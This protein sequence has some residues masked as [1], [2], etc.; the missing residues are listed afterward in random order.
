MTG[1]HRPLMEGDDDDEAQRVDRQTQGKATMTSSIANLCNTIIGTGMLA[2][3]G[4]FR[5]TGL[6][7]GIFLILLCGFTALAG[8]LLLT[9]CADTLGGRKNSFFS[10]A[11]HTLPRGARVFDAAI[12]IK[13]RGKVLK[14]PVRT[15]CQRVDSSVPQFLVLWCLHII[16]DH[17]RTAHASSGDIICESAGSA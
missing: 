8:L 7:P 14:G 9:L 15:W 17:L 2:T 10:I 13:V 5:Y 11:M 16:L 4:A 12:A 3:P 1:E 6:L